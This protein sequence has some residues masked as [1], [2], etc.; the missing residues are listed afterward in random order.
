MYLE[1]PREKW[2]KYNG[3]NRIVRLREATIPTRKPRPFM[4]PA[5][6]ENESKIVA[7]VKKGLQNA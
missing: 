7:D 3:S 4:I 1:F 6:K 5:F 2:K